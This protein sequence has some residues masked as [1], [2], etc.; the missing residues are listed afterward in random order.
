[1]SKPEYR[2]PIPEMKEAVARLD[3]VF[4]DVLADARH[5]PSGYEILGECLA[6]A[7][8]LVD[9]NRKYGDSALNPLRI[10]SKASPEEQILVR[11]D[12]KLSRIA[13][14]VG[15]N[16][17]PIVD[18]LGYLVLLRIAQKRSF[19]ELAASMKERADS[20]KKDAGGP[21]KGEVSAEAASIAKPIE[22]AAR[23]GETATGSVEPAPAVAAG[24]VPGPATPHSC[25]EC[26]KTVEAD[27]SALC[28]ACFKRRWGREPVSSV[29]RY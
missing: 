4:C 15:E 18:S 13:R 3:E 24:P 7:V 29:P 22:P 6:I 12:D 27:D 26:G 11:L 17:D 21:E 20:L 14:G 16:E 19:R 25:Q 10:F 1:M 5:T 28:G 23:A 9:K 2:A 8:M